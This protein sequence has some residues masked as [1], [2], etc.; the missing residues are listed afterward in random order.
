MRC[1]WQSLHERSRELC[2]RGSE[3]E[4]AAR[5]ETGVGSDA[6]RRD[7]ELQLERTSW[8]VRI[9]TVLQLMMR[10]WRCGHFADLVSSVDISAVINSASSLRL[11]QQY[12]PKSHSSSSPCPTTRPHSPFRHKGK[13]SSRLKSQSLDPRFAATSKLYPSTQRSAY[14][15]R[16]ASNLG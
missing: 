7:G 10:I 13:S 9:S 4:R 14:V 5:C 2:R 12:L 3:D 15:C 8:T 6:G 1:E 11:Q 16:R